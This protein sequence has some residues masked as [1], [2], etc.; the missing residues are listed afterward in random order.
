M[1]GSIFGG[2]GICPVHTQTISQKIFFKKYSKYPETCFK[3]FYMDADL[4]QNEH[5][6]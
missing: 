6:I 3:T 4:A 5:K 1:D 2:A